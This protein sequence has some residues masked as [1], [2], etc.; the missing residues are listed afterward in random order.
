MKKL[1]HGA[2]LRLFL[3]RMLGKQRLRKNYFILA[4]RFVMQVQLKERKQGNLLRLTGWKLKN[5]GGF[6]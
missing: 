6:R 3:T 1:H 4:V 5:N 2:H